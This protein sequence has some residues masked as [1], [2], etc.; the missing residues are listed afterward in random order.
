MQNRTN[1]TKMMKGIKMLN[2]FKYPR[3]K[4][5]LRKKNNQKKYQIKDNLIFNNR[6]ETNLWQ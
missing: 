5:K 2:R 6:K 4:N 3:Q 1:K